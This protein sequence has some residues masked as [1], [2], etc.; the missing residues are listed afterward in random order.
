MTRGQLM[1]VCRVMRDANLSRAQRRAVVEIGWAH[2]LRVT[3]DTLN[4]RPLFA[5]AGG[6]SS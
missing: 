4:D 3:D 2:N 6:R 5:I 1:R